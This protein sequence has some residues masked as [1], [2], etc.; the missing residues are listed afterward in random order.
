MIQQLREKR[1]E[2]YQKAASAFKKKQGGVAGY[3]SEEGRRLTSRLEDL[4]ARFRRARFRQ[5]NA[6]GGG[7][8]NAGSLDLH[9]L[10]VTEAVE[11]LTWFVE[12]KRNW[13]TRIGRWEWELN[14]LKAY[15][16]A[17]HF[18]FILR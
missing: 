1:S 11:Q 17:S 9:G 10:S 6:P 7:G 12:E 4:E 14:F 2:C 13:L 18:R 5:H 16:L 3:Y 15:L 8:G